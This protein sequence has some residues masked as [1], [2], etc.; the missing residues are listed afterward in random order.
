M[1]CIAT[2][3]DG[4][5]SRSTETMTPEQALGQPFG[6]LPDLIG[7]PIRLTVGKKTLEDGQVDLLVR[8]G[9][10]EERVPVGEIP[11]RVGGF[12]DGA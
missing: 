1:R 4:S 10:A 3:S 6:T 9:R 8:E 5:S 2:R 7:C 11:A 12:L